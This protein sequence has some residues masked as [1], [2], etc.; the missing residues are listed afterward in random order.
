MADYKFDGKYIRDSYGS[1][2]ATMDDV[3]KSIEGFGEIR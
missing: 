2:I 3:N 1:R